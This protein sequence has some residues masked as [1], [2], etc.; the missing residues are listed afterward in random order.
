MDINSKQN[1]IVILGGGLAGLSAGYVLSR[2]GK[3][4]LVAEGDSTVGGLSKTYKHN[5][6][7]FD[8]GGH[9]FITHNRSLERFVNELLKGEFL[10]VMRTSQIYMFGR[11]FDY[12]LKPVNAMFGLGILTSLQILLD[13]W[14]EKIKNVLKPP[15]II[16]LED[17]VVSQF[18]RKM[19]DLY[20]KEYS[21]K[22]WGIDCKSISQEWVSERIKGLSLWEA[23]KN[24]FTKVSGKSIKTLADEFIYPPYGIGQLSDNLKEGIEEA[25]SSVLTET[26]VIKVNHEN[27]NVSSITVDNNGKQYDIEGKEFISSVPLTHLAKMLHPAAPADIMEAASKLRYRDIVIVTV[28]L[29]R[30]KVTDLTWL[31]FPEKDMPLGRIHEPRNWS[32]YMAPEG[33]THV[34]AEFFCFKGDKI[35]NSSDEELTAITVENLEKLGF[36]NKNEVIDSSVVRAAKAYPLM[37]VGYR[38]PYEKILQYLKNF[39][40]LRPIGRGGLFKYYN[41]DRAIESGIEV[42]EEILGKKVLE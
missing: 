11:Y 1:G 10:K 33:K 6:F 27:F 29:D 23:I 24:G 15:E 41:M 13:Y 19:F 3:K 39:K 4:V 7:M 18:G 35:W 20:F 34:V 37:E 40:N 8:L 30:E 28:M 2:E 21:E 32:P 38:E 22:V 31:Y 36:I 9:R 17:W 25:G 12:P 5:G 16:S 26:R 14:K 42:A